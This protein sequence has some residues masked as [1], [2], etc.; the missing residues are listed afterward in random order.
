MGWFKKLFK[1]LAPVI[2]IVVAVFA[3]EILPFMGNAIAA[4]VGITVSATT[5]TA[6]GS[7]ALTTTS[8]LLAGATP[9]DALK[10]GL[11]SG[12][13]IGVGGAVT[14]GVT[15]ATGST[16]AGAAAGSATKGFIGSGGDL[17]T[18]LTSAVAGASATA[19]ASATDSTVA[20]K[21]VGAVI[22]SGGVNANALIN[23]TASIAPEIRT[24]NGLDT[25]TATASKTASVD[26]AADDTTTADA[27]SFQAPSVLTAKPDLIDA[28]NNANLSPEDKAYLLRGIQ[29]SDVA[30]A[31]PATTSDAGSSALG[32]TGFPFAAN[33]PRFNAALQNNPVL[34]Q[35]FSEYTNTY[36][37][38]S[39]Q[40]NVV[41]KSLL[42][43]E[44]AKDSTYQ[45]LLDE[46]KKITG[47]D[48]KPNVTDL[49]EI[50][51][52]GKSTS[53]KPDS[54]IITI[55][56]SK[57]KA[58][59]SDSTGKTSVVNIPPGV[60]FKPN[61]AVAVDPKTGTIIIPGTGPTVLPLPGT[62]TSP[63]TAPG[64]LPG[65]DPNALPNV[66]PS[67]NPLTN[68]NAATYLSPSI[69]PVITPGV[70]PTFIP[71]TVSPLVPRTPGGPT[72]SV[73][74]PKVY[75]DP[76]K[77]NDGTQPTD[78]VTPLDPI[79]PTE[80]T[81]PIDP[82]DPLDP[83]VITADPTVTADPNITP[84]DPTKTVDPEDKTITDPTIT[85]VAP[86]KVKPTPIYPTITG[87]GRSPL[88]QALTAFRPAGEIEGEAT[89]R[90]RED[91][92][93]EA[94]L[95]LKDA[96]GL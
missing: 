54:V 36:G 86:K 50:T 75:V 25:A 12:V 77:P 65:T 67:V 16:I 30:Q 13:A 74:S 89:G 37:L 92:W 20:G 76:S 38:N 58:L 48:Y 64:A 23:F 70:T 53:V 34:L 15:E 61:D 45:P 49:G 14:T 78:G 39:P 9:A 52:T 32:R 43:T 8:Q 66:S 44:L 29:G 55:D 6:M 93:N 47:T 94:S 2:M 88:A 27:S 35:K 81:E 91:V 87:A 40:L 84:V 82:L 72:K 4:E 57:N 42:E 19:V 11:T 46:Y 3:P 69:T 17:T 33:D 24:A 31:L 73:V 10:A 63:S 90:P 28:I 68:P 56:A 22:A 59:V 7:A 26:A 5:A 85:V 60:T 95:R 71:S 80:P 62:A 51:I 83:T 41:Y 96:L 21:A 18:A 1:A 79:Q